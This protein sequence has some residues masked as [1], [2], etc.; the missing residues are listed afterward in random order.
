[1]HPSWMVQAV[2]MA[3]YVQVLGA[4]VW[5]AVVVL[6][7][8]SRRGSRQRL[9][10]LEAELNW[11]RK[12]TSQAIVDAVDAMNS[13]SKTC[14]LRHENARLLAKFKSSIPTEEIE[15]TDP[16]FRLPNGAEYS[17]PVESVEADEHSSRSMASATWQ[18]EGCQRQ[19]DVYACSPGR[20]CEHC[21]GRFWLAEVP[22]SE[23]K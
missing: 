8:R 14:K 2:S 20:R 21:G 12:G 15:Q 23:A 5:L 3:I 13:L 7:E 1:M 11:F 10:Q 6:V 4:F 18:C 19:L 16:A 17:Q 9:E 22:M